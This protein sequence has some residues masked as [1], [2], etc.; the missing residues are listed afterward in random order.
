[1]ATDIAEAQRRLLARR[2]ESQADRGVEGIQDALLIDTATVKL[3]RR[4]IQLATQSCSTCSGERVWEC[5]QQTHDSG[6][7]YCYHLTLCECMARAEAER[8]AEFESQ[9]A[10]SRIEECWRACGLGGEYRSS[11][12]DRKDW[13]DGQKPMVARAYRW[14]I[15]R[16]GGVYAVG[17]NGCGKSSVGAGLVRECCDRGITAFWAHWPDF[18]QDIRLGNRDMQQYIARLSQV[19]LLVWDDF[20]RT[21]PTKWGVDVITEVIYNRESAGQSIW[22]TL[23]WEADAALEEM[24]GGGNVSRIA[25]MCREGRIEIPT[26]VPDYRRQG[27]YWWAE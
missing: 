5:N 25:G 7:L 17:H 6:V 23:N 1:M 16:T 19:E 3:S 8:S 14:L 15:E 4:P 12:L 21:T 2:A 10:R 18:V 13:H 24:I 27:T 26:A 9:A 11:R 20:C 22:F